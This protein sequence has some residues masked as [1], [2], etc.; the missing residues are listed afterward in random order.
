MGTHEVSVVYKS[1]RGIAQP[2]SA[3]NQNSSV[4]IPF[5]P[6]SGCELRVRKD[7]DK[8]VSEF[9]FKNLRHQSVALQDTLLN[10]L[11]PGVTP[12][13]QKITSLCIDKRKLLSVYLSFIN[14]C[15][16]FIHH[17]DEIHSPDGFLLSDGEKSLVSISGAGG[18]LEDFREFVMLARDCAVM[19]ESSE[20]AMERVAGKRKNSDHSASAS[21]PKLSKL[22]AVVQREENEVKDEEGLEHNYRNSYVGV[23][24]V[25]LKNISVSPE[26]KVKINPFRV[27]YIM[28]SM[29]KKYDPALSVLV[30][31]Q[32]DDKKKCSDINQEFY[33]VQK[34]HCL[35][36]FK[37]LNKTKEFE[38]FFGHHNGKVLCYIL[39]T[40]RRDMMQYGNARENMISADCYKKFGPQD[41]LHHFH[42]LTMKE[43]SS[44]DSLK[45][46]ERMAKLACVGPDECTALD[47]LCKWS[48]P[49]FVALMKVVEKFEHYQ[50]LDVKSTGNQQALEKGLKL[51]MTNVLL[52]LL[53]KVSEKYFLENSEQVMQ[54][55]ISLQQL[56]ENFKILTEVEKVYT[57]L[58]AMSHYESVA[59]LS[60]AYPGKF[61]CESLRPYIG[62]IWNDKTINDQGKRLEKFYKSVIAEPDEDFV[63]PVDFV[64]Y[65]D[66]KKVIADEDILTKSDMIIFMMKETN[67]DVIAD[68]VIEVLGSDKPFNAAL[69]VFPCEIDQFE[70]LSHLRSRKASTSLIKDFMLV[71]LLFKVELKH[72]GEVTENVKYSLLFGKMTV[73]KIPLK[74]CYDD[75]AQLAQVVDCICPSKKRVS[76]I[77]DHGVPCIKLHNTE[78]NRQVRY[79]GTAAA[80]AKFEKRLT[81]DK[82]PV[83][84]EMGSEQGDHEESSDGSVHDEDPKETESL[85]STSNTPAKLT[86]VKMDDSGFMENPSPSS[87]D[88]SKSLGF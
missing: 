44:L 51:R 53:A 58:S 77:C 84:D 34:V 32:V 29:R 82:T 78:L 26:M 66:I 62:A 76:L 7:G 31:C 72:G 56:A 21:A 11:L 4:K 55:K 37:E 71:P 70:V 8:T 67:K 13:S 81:A 18:S 17:R 59:T 28:S 27:Q 65:Q 61:G 40:N 85:P 38:S 46:V 6:P 23:A 52:R 43:D 19:V 2:L 10:N 54:S 30:V 63:S 48:K 9:K 3:S 1:T 16:D 42:C 25:E 57:A 88:C 68:I 73:L 87:S 35:Q 60:E 15:E 20:K 22:E 49:A 36:A 39:N 14:S 50:T 5:G 41:I 64:S 80:I 83:P 74:V 24:H 86:P 75:L 12:F 33:V 79:F 69:L 45:M 47:K